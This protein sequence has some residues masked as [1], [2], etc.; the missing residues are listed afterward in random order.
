MREPIKRV[1]TPFQTFVQSESASGL[2]LVLMAI[3]AFAWAN[4]PWAAGYETLKH[5]GISVG[6]GRFALSQ[7]LLHWVNDG[8]MALF[9]LMVGLEIKREVIDGDLSDARAALLPVLAAFGGMVIPA[10][11]YVAVNRDAAAGLDGWGIPMATDIAFSLG[12]MALLGKRVPQGLKVFLTALA[13]VDDLGAVIVI[14]VFYSHGLDWASLG[15]VMLIWLAALFYGR[16]R[17]HRLGVYA[18]LGLVMW[19]F[20]L[21]SGIHATVAGI[22][23]ALALPLNRRGRTRSDTG[24]GSAPLHRMEHLLEPWVAYFIVPVFALFNAGFSLAGE[25]AFT[26]PVI[27]GAFLGLLLGK[28]LG[29]FGSSWLAVKLN[30]AQLPPAVSWTHLLGAG[31]LAGIGFTM[32]LF[33]AD[34]AFGQSQLLDYAKLGVL[35]ASL[36]SALLGLLILIFASRLR[37]SAAA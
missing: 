13:I 19:F 11:I 5:Y 32:S 7:S 30:L 23:L 27:L 2:L 24:A 31:V 34:L 29:V 6:W 10:L 14:A 9:F 18:L 36:V 17:G 28:P 33:V 12:I 1:L 26:Q 20:M 4:S 8:L 22:L 16:R 35:C 25:A 3:I 37:V 21:R 15:V